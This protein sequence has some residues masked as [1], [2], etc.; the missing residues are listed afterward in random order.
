[1]KTI[2]KSKVAMQSVMAKG[3]PTFGAMND[4]KYSRYVKSE[5]PMPSDVKDHNGKYFKVVNVGKPSIE[6]C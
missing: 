3:L 4:Q 1:M 6:N 5:A 2:P